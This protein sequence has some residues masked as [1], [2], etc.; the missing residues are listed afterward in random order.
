MP[1]ILFTFLIE[2]KGKGEDKLTLSLRVTVCDIKD[3]IV[4]LLSRGTEQIF[5]YSIYTYNFV[6]TFSWL[7]FICRAV[8]DTNLLCQKEN[9]Y[10][11]AFYLFYKG[12]YILF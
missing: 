12:I 3:G 5:I 1:K 4:V 2:R 6:V 8:L 7:P 9:K 10:F 11:G